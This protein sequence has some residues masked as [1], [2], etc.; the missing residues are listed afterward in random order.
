MGGRG[1][2]GHNSKRKL[3]DVQCARLDVHE[4]A[5]DGKLTL[6]KRGTLFGSI[7]FEV[8]GGPDAQRFVLEFPIRSASGDRLD[9]VRQV[10]CCY[11]R[12]AHYGGRYLMFLCSECGRSARVLYARYFSDRIWF[13]ACRKCAGLT[14]QSTMGHRWDRSR[15]ESKSY[16]PA[17]NGAITVP[18]RSG[19]EGCTSGRIN[20]SWAR[21]PTTRLFENRARATLANTGQIST[22]LICGCSAETGLGSLVDGRSANR[23]W[24][25]RGHIPSASNTSPGSGGVRRRLY[26]S[27]LTASRK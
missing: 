14:Y 1:S 23:L 2:G 27:L 24:G 7:G 18:S 19:R 5:R 11:W 21:S 12:R 20:E 13:F 9:P 10:I 16:A 8:A 3:R 6:G 17:F 25:N 26:M 15:V 22:A 4:L